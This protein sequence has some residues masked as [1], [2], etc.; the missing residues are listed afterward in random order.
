MLVS[1]RENP[2]ITSET[3]LVASADVGFRHQGDWDKRAQGH[4]L[5]AYLERL[6]ESVMSAFLLDRQLC[7]G[8]CMAHSVCCL[9]FARSIA[10]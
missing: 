7:S 5:Q 3:T 2:G 6:A 4:L 9:L 8:I 1:L 10:T